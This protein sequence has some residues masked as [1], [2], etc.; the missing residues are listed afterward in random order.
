MQILPGNFELYFDGTRPITIGRELG[1]DVVV[2]GVST[3]RQHGL[4]R[5]EAGGAGRPV[6]VYEDRSSNGTYLDGKRIQR[7][8]VDHP[9]VL[10]LGAGNS[11]SQI[12]LTPPSAAAGGPP[13]QTSGPIAGHAP[14]QPPPQPHA[15]PP[16]PAQQPQ[17]PAQPP[18]Y[19]N[20][21]PPPQAN[22]AQP[23][24]NGNAGNGNNNG[25][26]AEFHEQPTRKA[27]PPTPGV[28]ATQPMPAVPEPVSRPAPQPIPQ[29]QLPKQN[30]PHPA[31]PVFTAGSP[32][33][34]AF[35]GVVRTHQD[36]MRIGRALDNEIVVDDLL[37]SRHHAELRKTRDG[38]YEIAD[39]GTHNGTF[40]DGRRIT[41]RSR[42]DEGSLVAI[43]H[44]LL[45]LRHGHLEGYVDHGQASFA[46]LDLGVSI[47]EKALLDSVSF[48]LE[49]GQFLAVLGP[50]GAG[51]S[52][53]LKALTGFR[54]ADRGIVLYNG[55]DVYSAFDELRH[56]IGYVP[57]DDILHPQLT[58]RSALEYAAELR[59]PP[60]VSSSERSGRV[61][62]VMRELGLEQRAD[63]RIERLSG[64]QRKRT[65]VALELLT[66]PSLLILDEPTSGLDPGYE[67]SVMQLL[68]Q[69]A[70]GGRTVLT[71]THSI[72]SLDLCDRIL[73][74]AP[75]GQTAYFGPP[76]DTLPF[77]ATPGYPE[78]F[79][80]LDRA[81]PGVAKAK[82]TG[83]EI[84]SQYVAAPLASQRHKVQP[85]EAQIAAPAVT[86]KSPHFARQLW[87]L[88]RR[89]SSLIV[90][91]RRNTL[92]LL[93][94]APILGLLMIAAFGKDNLVP[95]APGAGSHATTVLLALTL[96]ASYLGASNAI[97]EIVKERPILIRERSVGLSV[98]PYVLSKFIVLGV[99]TV[100]ESFIMVYMALAR[101]GGLEHGQVIGNGRLEIA[102]VV[103]LSGLCSMALG[104]W[105]SSLAANADKVMTI[106]P[107]ILF[108]QF[109]L[110]GAAF[111]VQNTAGLNQLAYF[112]SARWSY[113]AEASTS[114]LDL[115]EGDGCN[116]TAPPGLAGKVPSLVNGSCDPA[117]A[118]TATAW[119]EDM[120]LLVGLTA[121]FTA[122]T[123]VAI[124]A[125]GR[126][127]RK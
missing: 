13:V 120:A 24:P 61:V 7:V 39:L 18:Q 121:L 94:Q 6:W 75:G 35:T 96:A 89:Y 58:V 50:T 54:P 59:F 12:R 67:K 66:R 33:P 44:T 32:A 122:G 104:L 73:F 98:M 5:L 107:V 36:R 93:A 43:G 53:L 56:R 40:V 3:S 72:Q 97:R 27:A 86:S 31:A 79:Q 126:P 113:S 115:I 38:G 52:T 16:I 9:L 47:G 92:L 69:L 106:L 60:D 109:V 99:I 51:K 21:Q 91:D 100:A 1:V 55:R 20:Q 101:Q 65:S 114:D 8:V 48:G 111:A 78:I 15:Q 30:V 4:L 17:A 95:G 90:A 127:K 11:G 23:G 119:T 2:P 49:G 102:L 68:R 74:L 76:R 26:A 118:P 81:E 84:E 103:S 70:D 42:L 87:T 64:G 108:A 88:T 110:C 85:P 45:R 83:S 29:N 125:I 71:V 105:V 62:E 116:N 80:L 57:Q 82:F 117:H 37:A 124:R 14:A 28:Y 22:Q 25:N 112:S 10:A 34:A 77:F 19:Q 46:A 123:G 41:G 63:V